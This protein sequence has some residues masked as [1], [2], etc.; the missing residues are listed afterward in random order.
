MLCLILGLSKLI[1][2]FDILTLDLMCT[3][4]EPPTS[5]RIEIHYSHLYSQDLGQMQMENLGENV[6][7]LG[8]KSNVRSDDATIL[9]LLRMR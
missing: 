9:I 1:V 5:W 8:L 3:V 4:Y 2:G 7:C 6:N